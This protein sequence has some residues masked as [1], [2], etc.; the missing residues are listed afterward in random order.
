[1]YR[2]KTIAHPTHDTRTPSLLLTGRDGYT[3]F[4]GKIPEGTQRVLNE[5]K[6]KFGRMR[7]VFF[8]GTFTQWPDIGGLPGF[9]LTLSDATKKG[10]SLFT[11]NPGLLRYIIA[12]WR[13]FVFRKGID[14]EVIE[15]GSHTQPQVLGD[16]NFA[17]RA[18][19]VLPEGA[20]EPQPSKWNQLLRDLAGHMF[21]KDTSVVNSADPDSYTI[22]PTERDAHTHVKLPNPEEV[23]P[24]AQQPSTSYIIRPLPM[25]GRFDIQKAK[26]AGIKPGPAFKILEKGDPIENDQGELVYPHQVMTP[27]QHFP[28]VAVI[29]IPNSR[30]LKPTLS[31]EAWFESSDDYGHEPVGVVYHFLGEDIDFKSDEYTQFMAKF[32][33]ET[34]HI[35]SH[36]SLTNHTL[37]FKSSAAN[38]LKLRHLLSSNINLPYI[39]SFEA[40]APGQVY[41]LQQLQEV[42]L[43]PDSSDISHD[44]VLSGDWNV[45][46][47]A[48]AEEMGETSGEDRQR[49]VDPTPIPLAKPTPSSSL[50]DMVQVVTLGTGS[51]IP[52]LHRNV[53]STLVRIPHQS[54]SGDITYQSIMLDGGE[55]TLGTMLRNYG[56]NNLAQFNQVM[57]ELRMIHLS[58]LHADHHIGLVSVISKWF[59]VNQDNQDTLWLVLP[60][61]FHHFL[62]EWYALE[63]STSNIDLSRIRYLSC[64]NFLPK[65]RQ[66]EFLQT[67]LDQFQPGKSPQR[68]PLAPIDNATIN[69][70]Y[71]DLHLTQLQTVRAIHCAWAYSIAM[72]FDLGDGETFKI[73]YSGDTRPN[74]RF[75]DIGINS[76][77]LVHESSLDN[78]LIE[79]AIAKKHSTM[80]EAVAVCQLM[81][82]P[83]I[84]LTHFST[85]YSNVGNMA[86]NVDELNQLAT[87]LKQYLQ[88]SDQS[89]VVNI[90]KQ[91][92]HRP[93]RALEDIE[94]CFAFDCFT[95]WLD[96]MACQR[97]Q[98]A[99]IM[100]VLASG[101]DQVDEAKAEKLES[102]RR[103]KR[104]AKRESRLSK[105]RKSG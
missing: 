22:D 34:K 81:N 104:E 70:M 40:L 57:T 19:T 51:A 78:E 4:F 47:D 90:W 14:V 80:I 99:Q 58:H 76:D 94:I 79:E 23:V 41:K 102:K 92:N 56:H 59:E 55:N 95:V 24:P 68:A 54:E 83:K 64:E 74:P 13:Y 93:A 5:N 18:I 27:P 85:R 50:K 82:C 33:P 91:F 15:V 8:T 12:N 29:D 73:A 7:S 84:M 72:T 60:W 43:G 36:P 61:Q 63:G 21:P 49:V 101:T 45:H 31:S 89:N 98:Y 10:I 86:N 100:E 46:Y 1:M 65:D 66:A 25:R 96:E 71:R 44:E 39:E 35:V 32:G 77:L 37:V 69:D 30:Y 48:V 103:E 67:P 3:Y 42:S 97:P 28:K 105:R 87:Q 53:I 17:V 2:I 75:V 38:T 62:S 20:P 26:A 52:S 11:G 88:Q 9:L 6:A 16:N